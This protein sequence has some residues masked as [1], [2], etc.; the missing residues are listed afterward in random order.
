MLPF[1]VT[2]GYFNYAK[3]AYLYL[4]NMLKIYKK[5]NNSVSSLKLNFLFFI[6][7]GSNK[8]YSAIWTDMT[9]EQT[10]IRNIHSREG[11]THGRGVTS[12]T[13]ARWITS[14][15]LHIVIADQLEKF[16]NFISSGT[17]HQHKDAGSLRIERN[18]KDVK[19]LK[20]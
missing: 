12:A 18:E 3:C 13:T 17:S 5:L 16:C 15:S 11:L 20:E 10:Y 4:Q 9:N 14:I 19:T 1:F 8:F 6:R 7:Y 2:S